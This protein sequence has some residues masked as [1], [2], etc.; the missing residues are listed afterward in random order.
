MKKKLG[1]IPFNGII[2][3][4]NY[5]CTLNRTLQSIFSTSMTNLTNKT[6]EILH[7]IYI[8]SKTKY[9]ALTI[10]VII[11]SVI[12]APA[13]CAANKWLVQIDSLVSQAIVAGKI[14]GAVVCIVHDDSISYLRAYGNR[15]VYP[16]TAPMKT[17][18]IFDLASLSKPTGTAMSVMVLYER[19]QLDFA[20]HVSKYIEGFNDTIT[21]AHLLTHTSGLPAYLNAERMKQLYGAPAPDSLMQHITNLSHNNAPGS[22]RYSCLNFITLQNIVEHVSGMKLKDFYAK[23]IATPLHLTSSAYCPPQSW[24]Q[25]IAPTENIK[26]GRRKY[27]L[28]HGEVH[29]PLARVMNGGNSG[30]AGLFSNAED[31][32]RLCIFLLNPDKIIGPISAATVEKMTTIP[33][34]FEAA[35]RTLGWDSQSDYNGCL[36]AFFSSKSICH[37]GYTGTSLAID[38]ERR[39][40]LI[41]LT[42][43]VH[44]KDK[45]GVGKL[46]SEIANCVAMMYPLRDESLRYIKPYDCK[47]DDS[48]PFIRWRGTEPTLSKSA[49][50]HRKKLLSRK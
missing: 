35:G 8:K 23:E 19:G 9:I 11:L 16:T 13:A 24:R 25:R 18:T 42:N 37:T 1:S 6:K 33:E 46:R 28:L 12:F 36:G 7:L 2:F 44:P 38:P 43:R 31:I 32:A 45:G 50:R 41:V 49:I 39:V 10:F 20:D 4:R 48:R 22:F 34:G 5:Y 47:I 26:E 3:D 21:I 14:P 15:Q 30:N 40:A 27:R 17:N 29:D